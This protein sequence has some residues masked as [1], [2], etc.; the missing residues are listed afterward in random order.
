[1]ANAEDLT[2]GAWFSPSIGISDST[3]RLSLSSSIST[4]SAT[5]AGGLMLDAKLD[6]I[7][8]RLSSLSGLLGSRNEHEG[9]W[10]VDKL[11]PPTFSK[12]EITSQLLKEL[13]RKSQLL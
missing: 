8:Q 11:I 2:A 1:M 5:P 9:G 12:A 10:P 7:F 13:I 6:K 3:R 4:S